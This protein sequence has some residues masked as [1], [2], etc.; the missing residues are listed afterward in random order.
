MQKAREP[1]P[2]LGEKVLGGQSL[3]VR[4]AEP[5][6][7]YVPAGQIVHEVAPKTLESDPATHWVH[8]VEPQLVEKKPGGQM[9]LGRPPPGHAQPGKHWPVVLVEPTGHHVPA[10][11]AKHVAL[12]VAPVEAE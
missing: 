10:G 2:G 5:A 1:A 4:D 7:K 6:S 3:H 9:R 12:E 8:V 11:H